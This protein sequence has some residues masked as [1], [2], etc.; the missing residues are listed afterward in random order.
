MPLPSKMSRIAAAAGLCSLALV[1]ACGSSSTS[2]VSDT[3]SG[4]SPVANASSAAS[5]HIVVGTSGDFPPL[6]SLDAKTNKVVGF[7]NDMMTAVTAKLGWTFEWKQITFAGLI[8][9]LSSKRLDAIVSGMYDTEARRA[10]VDFVDY[11]QVPLAVMTTTANAAKTKGADNLCGESVAY[12]TSSP[13]ELDQIQAWSKACTTAGNKAITAVPFESVSQA[14]NAVASGR[15]FGEL[16]GDIVTIYISQTQFG[17]KLAVAFNVEGGTSTAGL[18]TSKNSPY[19][20][21]LDTAIKAYVASDAYCAA[22]K[23]WNLTAGDTLRSCS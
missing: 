1:T 15:V 22:A 18:A 6:S 4:S 11:M 14:V 12:I 20:A 17:N 19:K 21:Q 10:Q 16:E 9:A 2:K 23:K 3:S 13:P 5:K 7:E 8:P